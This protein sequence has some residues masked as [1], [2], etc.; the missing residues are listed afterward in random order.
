MFKQRLVKTL[1]LSEKGKSLDGETDKAV[2]KIQEQKRLS[3]QEFQ[4][5]YDTIWKEGPK[6]VYQSPDAWRKDKVY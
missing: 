3:S 1:K 4:K 2:T 5:I 6:T